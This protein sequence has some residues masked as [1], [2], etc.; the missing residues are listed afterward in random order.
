MKKIRLGIGY[1][2]LVFS[3]FLESSF[4]KPTQP[5]SDR[6]HE[7]NCR[8]YMQI[9]EGIMRA[10]Q[11]GLSLAKA[12]EFNDETNIKMKDDNMHKIMKLMIVDAYKQPSYTSSSVKQEQLNDFSAKYYIGCS[13][14]YN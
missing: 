2:F 3:V 14:M 7:N 4:A 5:V 12:L 1:V 6:E 13:E 11:N 10:K 9:A 8:M